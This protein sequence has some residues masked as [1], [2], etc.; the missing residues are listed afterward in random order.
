MSSVIDNDDEN[1]KEI[2]IRLSYIEKNK[3]KLLKYK[4]SKFLFQQ[5]LNNSSSR[6][7]IFILVV[8]KSLM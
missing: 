2:A 3:L 1:E 7:N 8:H 4:I 5:T 6:F